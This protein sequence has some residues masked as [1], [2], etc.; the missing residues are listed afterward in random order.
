MQGNDCLHA[1]C[2]IL[3]T[4]VLQMG[5]FE[6]ENTS[7]RRAGGGGETTNPHDWTNSSFSPKVDF[8]PRYGT[9]YVVG[10]P[11]GLPGK[12]NPTSETRELVQP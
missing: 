4:H 12:E 11:P 7:L 1:C 6:D 3:S 2:L 5:E 8:V 10:S 9:C